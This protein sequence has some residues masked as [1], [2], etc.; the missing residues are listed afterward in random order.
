M[1]TLEDRIKET[2]ER[3]KYTEKDISY[4]MA[5]L[6]EKKDFVMVERSNLECMIENWKDDKEES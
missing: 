4:Q 3:L 2:I 1:A 6:S 5:V